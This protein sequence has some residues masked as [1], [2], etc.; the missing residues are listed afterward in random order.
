[1]TS[2]TFYGGVKEIGGNKILLK[3]RDTKVFL[4]FGVSLAMKRRYYTTP[5]FSPRNEKS[6]LEFGILPKIGGIYRFD[7]SARDLDAVFLSHSHSD[8]SAYISFLKRSI[9]NHI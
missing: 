6:L 8:H 7:E 5:L 4:D 2:L 3:D 1:M 9:L